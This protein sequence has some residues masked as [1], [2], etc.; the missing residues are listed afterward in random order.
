MN[1]SLATAWYQ[2]HRNRTPMLVLS[3]LIAVTLI[4][5]QFTPSPLSYFDISSNLGTGG[6]LA[7]A[8]M[9]LA[10][11]VITRGIDLSVGAVVSLVSV[12]VGSTMTDSPENQIVV[13]II[14]VL[15]GAAAGAVNGILIAYLRIQPIVVTLA[16]LFILQGVALLVMP[17]PGGHITTSFI[18]FFAGDAIPKLVPAALVVILAAIAFWMVL[19]NS[20]LGTAIYAIGSDESAAASNGVNTARVKFLAYTMAGGFYG[21]AGLFITA[22]AG[23]S[24]P[25]VGA[26]MLIQVFTAVVLGGTSLAGGRG[27]LVGPVFGAFLL[28][29]TVNTLMVFS[30]P[31]FLSPIFD[32]GILIL[33]VVL[34]SLMSE[35]SILHNLSDIYRQVTGDRSGQPLRRS[36]TVEENMSEVSLP[37]TP[38]RVLHADDIR[39]V[40]PALAAFLIIVGVTV[41]VFGQLGGDYI[42]SLLLLSALL[43]VLAFGQATVIIT[44][45]LDLSIPWAITLC[46]VVFS[47]VVN[48]SDAALAWS[49]PAVIGLGVLIGLINGLGVVVL[50]L[51]PLVITLAMNGILQGM[52]LFYTNGSPEGSAPPMLR[53]F[54]G[55]SIFG[56]QPVVWAFVPFVIL[57]SV[58]LT[59]TA[60]GRRLY[61]VGNSAVVANLSGINVRMTTVLAYVICGAST[62]LAA[63]LLVGFN[64]AATLSMGD[65]YLLPSVAVVVAGGVLITGGRGH[66]PGVVCGVLM[67]IALYILIGGTMLPDAVRSII[68]G[69]VLMAALLALR[70]GRTS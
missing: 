52:T 44:G 20:R 29:S 38:W 22:Q 14:G 10:L 54:V 17:I 58:F 53:W 56:L 35:N 15:I 32:G 12:F 50:G 21:L 65:Q 59:A 55:G 26:A 5:H 68:L 3:L 40:L 4:T 63:M 24:D 62:G 23:G 60:A 39:Q 37:K 70:E 42:R 31:T 57:A 25:L 8:A 69:C 6:G 47:S 36:F 64:G 67:L 28:M 48:G 9:G 41:A 30:M 34:S 27:G 61:A 66:Y 1:D 18:N 16:T 51:P 33:A 13:S 43:G 2:L 19:R 7:L 49:I 46:A 45:G 11:V